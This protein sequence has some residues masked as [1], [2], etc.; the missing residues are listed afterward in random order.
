MSNPQ[1]EQEK[2]HMSNHE[3]HQKVAQSV[4]SVCH[5]RRPQ[6]ERNK[7]REFSY[8]ELHAA[9]QGF[10]PKNF[11][12]EGG[13]GSV[14]K[15]ELCGQKIAVKQHMCANRKGEKEFK[16]EVD[17]LSKAIHENVVMLLG[18][19]SEG[20]H[21]LLVYEYVCNGSLDQHLSQHSRKLL[22]WQDRVKVADGAA[23]GLL[24]L[25]ENNIIHRDMTTNNILLTHD[26]DVLLGDFGLART[27]IEDSS[28]STE[29]V[30]N[31]TYMAPEYAEFGKVSIKTDVYSF[32]VVL[33]QL[34]TG[35][36]TT[37]KRVADKGLVG[38]A[39]PLLK[40]GKC[41]A[42]IDGRMINSHDCHQ[43][44]WMSR[45]AGNCLQ[46]DPEKRLHMSTV[47]KALNQIGKGCSCIVRKDHNLLI[48]SPSSTSKDHTDYSSPSQ[49]WSES[50]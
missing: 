9:T 1:V 21:R 3:T 45:L 44:Y 12:S 27:V 49:E 29:C 10:S 19:C 28:Y 35:M 17:A 39:R 50:Q 31:L 16:S 20:N 46:R 8:V 25:H 36:R 33:L 47:V 13:F 15:G 32:G 42:L 43:L 11:L 14:Y 34:I 5:N 38:W 4:C 40:E 24:Y 2:Q 26:Y 22:N 23:K 18:S 7:K 6:F 48:S 41:Q 37:D 30:G